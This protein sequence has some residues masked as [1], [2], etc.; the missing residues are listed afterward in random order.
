MV[1]SINRFLIY[2]KNYLTLSSSLLL[3]ILF[4]TIFIIPLFPVTYHRIL[5]SV[6]YTIIFILSAFSVQ[7]LQKRVMYFAL[8]VIVVEWISIILNMPI[9]FKISLPINFIFFLFMVGILIIQ[10]AKAKDVTILV[11]LESISVYLLLGISFSIIVSLLESISPNSFNFNKISGPINSNYLYNI[12]YMYFTFVSFTSTGY[13]DYL[14]LTP[15]A[16]S[17]SILISIIGQLYIAI[18]IAMIV[19]K[20]LSKPSNSN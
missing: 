9:L 10:I 18:I 13:G 3:T 16:K 7:Y 17:L 14:P 2:T 6:S 15:T 11:L 1:R 8:L 4:I 5:F 12:D 19:G 20:Y